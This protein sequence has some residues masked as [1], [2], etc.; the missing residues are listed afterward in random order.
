M[1][2]L[3][4]H[5]LKLPN[6]WSK[7][8]VAFEK[9]VLLVTCCLTFKSNKVVREAGV[10]GSILLRFFLEMS[11]STL[12][13][14]K[15]K[16]AKGRSVNLCIC[17]TRAC[18]W[19]KFRFLFLSPSPSPCLSCFRRASRFLL[20]PIFHDLL[21]T[22]CRHLILLFYGIYS[23]FLSSSLAMT[24]CP[25]YRIL[26]ANLPCFFREIHEEQL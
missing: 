18:F 14:L 2:I 20:K 9:M 13:K 26:C 23:K 21:M 6:L 7:T 22:K 3:R 24:C 1:G 10:W 25:I 16:I 15:W 8:W 12:S 17:R 19:H 4:V 5:L 11:T